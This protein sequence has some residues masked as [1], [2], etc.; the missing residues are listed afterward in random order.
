MKKWQVVKML[1]DK[2]VV[3]KMWLTKRQVDKMAIA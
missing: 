1:V 2:T 3:N